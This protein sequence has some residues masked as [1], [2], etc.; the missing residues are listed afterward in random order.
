MGPLTLV[1]WLFGEVLKFEQPFGPGSRLEG[2]SPVPPQKKEKKKKVRLQF[3]YQT[4]FR[5]LSP[6]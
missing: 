4:K 6:L 1:R 5:D 2:V 3:I